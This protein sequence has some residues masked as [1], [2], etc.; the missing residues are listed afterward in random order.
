MDSGSNDLK[1]GA[2]V[3][4]ATPDWSELL[5]KAADDLARVVSG[6]IRLLEATVKQVI[7]AQGEKLAGVLVALLA[8][9]Y[10]FLLL[11]GAIVLF[12]HLWLDWWLSLLITA[13]AVIAV[14]VFFQAWTARRA[15]ARA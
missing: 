11:V 5:S 2:S 4:D 14:G 10:G 15:R 6:E 1:A 8:F 7:E 13:V 3:S 12:I 9:G